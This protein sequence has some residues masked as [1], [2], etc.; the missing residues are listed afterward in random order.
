MHAGDATITPDEV[1][2]K[3]RRGRGRAVWLATAAVGAGTLFWHAARAFPFFADDAFISLRYAQRLLEGRGLTWTDGDAVEGYSNLLWVLA[4]AGLGALGVDLVLAARVLGGV[5]SAAA[6]LAVVGAA[7]PRRSADAFPAVV[8]ALAFALSGSVA[9]WTLGG[10]EQPLLAALLAWACVLAFPLLEPGARAGARWLAP[11]ALLA[12]ACLTRP[13]GA[14]LAGACILGVLWVRERGRA[15]LDLAARLALLPAVA[16]FSQLAFRLAYYGEWLP[17]TAFVKLGFGA[18]RWSQ[19]A[20]YLLGGLASLLPLALLAAGLCAAL[21]RRGAAARRSC[22]LAAPML[23]WCVY[24][25]AI[26]GDLFPAWRHFTPVVVCLAL[27][28]AVALAD[29]DARPG[30]V[31]VAAR[32]GSLAALILLAAFQLA[33]PQN[34]RAREERWEWDGEVVGRLLG[35]A[36]AAE[37]PLVAVDPAG[38]V[39]FFSRLPA[40]DMLGL[41][42]RFLAHQR[43]AEFGAGA[44]GHELGN[45]DYVLSRE[46]DLVLFCLPTGGLEPCFLSGV[47]MLRDPRFAARY[48]LI[49]L[50][51]REPRRVRTRLWAR[52]EGGRI[53]IE[54]RES[55]I[56][57]PAW[58]ATGSPASAA[59]LGPD[60]RLRVSVAERA[61]AG[62]AALLLAPGRWRVTPIGVG[63]APRVSVA[64]TGSQ[65]WRTR[66]GS[67]AFELAASGDPR[68]DVLVS[69]A[70]SGDPFELERLHFE[71]SPL[72]V[73]RQHPRDEDEE[74]PEAQPVVVDERERAARAKDEEGARREQEEQ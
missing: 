32:A 6:L 24:V 68:V 65:A 43:P 2:A 14:L 17:N 61:P 72:E 11:G 67:L 16:V 31:R 19:G 38:A 18:A 47:E 57:V 71:R 37:Q 9:V 15:R 49:Q 36:F 22:F 73:E 54:R 10:L 3:G 59:H 41:C 69:A 62:L 28:V 30:R 20:T 23:F 5:C 64:P 35:A 46:P 7:A 34:R 55:Q 51:G 39:P 12:L 1:P 4:C 63:S 52:A 45:G 56:V 58:F 26:G 25:V 60:G 21:P 33:D 40:L 8:G 74:Q 48:R 42:D 66:M 70:G 29:L 27:I 50:E 44:V 13:D 53:G